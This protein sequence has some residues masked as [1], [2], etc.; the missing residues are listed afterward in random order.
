M[1][2][3]KKGIILELCSARMRR[4]PR[5][6]VMRRYN[7]WSC[8]CVWCVRSSML[9]YK[10][11]NTNGYF[12]IC[13]SSSSNKCSSEMVYKYIYLWCVRAAYSFV[14][15][16]CGSHIHASSTI[17]MCIM[18]VSAPLSRTSKTAIVCRLVC[19]CVACVWSTQRNES[20]GMGRPQ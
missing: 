6:I 15:V 7:V 20:G 5:R 2:S 19:M 13:A 10:N 16:S 18:Y 8:S 17:Y 1:L 12:F 3:D 9:L 4:H 11:C 14:C